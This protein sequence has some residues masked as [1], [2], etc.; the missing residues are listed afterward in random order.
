MARSM[1]G[2]GRGVVAFALILAAVSLAPWVT[3]RTAHAAA[4][5]STMTIVMAEEPDTLDPQ[6]SD[7]AISDQILRYVGDPLI[8]LGIPTRRSI[9]SRWFAPFAGTPGPM[10]ESSSA[11]RRCWPAFLC[12]SRKSRDASMLPAISSAR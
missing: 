12:R 9:T 10:V 4:T 1:S 5:Q 3:Q 11:C 8:Y 7:T 6:K 2:F